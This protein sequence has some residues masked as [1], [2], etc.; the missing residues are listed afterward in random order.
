MMSRMTFRVKA[1]ENK[2]VRALK[3][4]DGNLVKGEWVPG[5]W[6]NG[7]EQMQFNLGPNPTCLYVEL[8]KY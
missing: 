7:D 8:Y 3:L 5:R 6:Q 2:K 1:W 4:E